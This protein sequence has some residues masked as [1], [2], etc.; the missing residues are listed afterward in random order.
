M[1]KGDLFDY[2]A[3]VGDDDRAASA[4][5][6]V[7]DEALPARDHGRGVLPEAG[8]EATCRLDFYAAVPHVARV[9]DDSRLVDFALIDSPEAVLCTVQMHLHRHERVVLARRQART[10]GLGSLRSRSARG[11]D[12]FA[13]AFA[14]PISC[15]G[16]RRARARVREDER[17]R[18]DPRAGADPATVTYGDTT[19]SPSR[20]SAAR[21]GAPGEVTTEWLKKKRRVCSSTTARTGTARRS[22]RCTPC[23][24]SR[25][26]PSR[27][28]SAGTS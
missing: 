17:R 2:Y 28:R 22:R 19:S 21:A 13:L 5:P 8:A 20:L 3:R 1:T 27:P 23:D 4:G 24:R 18:R 10:P 7:H 25:A 15:A 6:P 26:H 12:A 11:A 14:S 9:K 16:S